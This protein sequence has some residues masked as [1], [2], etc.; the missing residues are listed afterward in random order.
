MDGKVALFTGAFG[1]PSR[2]GETLVRTSPIL[3]GALCFLIGE[4]AGVFNLGGEGALNMG[5]AGV[6]LV[7]I[8]IPDIVPSFLGI[9]C[10]YISLLLL[11]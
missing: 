9:P 10:T 6:A 5:A 1:S 3:L 7:A 11:L 8:L 4:K 2:I